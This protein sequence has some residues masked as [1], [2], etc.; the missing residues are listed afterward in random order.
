MRLY[1]SMELLR[2]QKEELSPL[3]HNYNRKPSPADSRVSAVESLH[4]IMI[5]K[6][7]EKQKILFRK[8]IVHFY[9]V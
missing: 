6:R 8:N 2:L 4:H 5:T 3:N 7:D 9:T 1:L